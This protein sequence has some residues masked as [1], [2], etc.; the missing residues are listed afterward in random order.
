MTTYPLSEPATI[1]RTDTSGGERKSVAR[2]SLADCADILA[3]WSSEDRATVEIEVDDMALR[4]GSDEIEE[5]LQFL[6]EEDAD[7]K[8]PAG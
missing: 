8:S 4:Y 5:L 1:Y 6:R 2:G 7:R 3:G